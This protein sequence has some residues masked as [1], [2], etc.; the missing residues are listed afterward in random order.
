MKRKFHH[1]EASARELSGPK[2]WRSLDELADTPGFRA[3][4]EREFP[5]GAAEWDNGDR[6]HFLKLMAA[7]FALGGIG[8]A[9]CR[10]PEQN[11]LPFGK[12]VEGII[13]GLP[14]YYATAMPLRK[15][16]IPLLAETHQGRPTKLEGNPTYELHGGAASLQAQ[17]SV[18][19]LYD[20]DRATAHTKA[21]TVIDAKAVEDLLANLGRTYGATRGA[22]LAFLA[23]E[24]SS[25]TR[26]RL[27]ARLRTTFPSAIWAEYE[28]TSDEADPAG[29]RA[30]FGA[31]VK[32]LYRFA[33]A[34]KIVSLDSDFLH[35]E[36]GSLYYARSFSNGRRVTKKED[37]MNRLYVAES[38]L[39]LTGSMADHRLRLASSHILALAAALGTKLIANP[40]FPAS[41]ADGL[42]FKDKDKWIAAC[43]NDLLRSRGRSLVI[44]GA[45]QPAQVHAI[46]YAINDFL[47]NIGQ[48]VDFVTVPAT[49]AASIS[50]VANAI[51][52]NAVKTLIVLGGNPAY[53]APADLDWPTLQ[54]SVNEV[55]RFGGYVDETSSVKPANTT[56]LAAAH[57]LESWGDART[58]D[59]VIVPIQPMILPL[60]GGL[61]EIEVLARILGEANADPYALVS[62]TIVGLAGPGRPAE[63]VMTKFLHDGLLEGSAYPLARVRYNA[64]A[65]GALFANAPKA[66]A[67]SK[68][69]LEVRFVSDY[70]LDDGRFAN[71]GWLQECPDPIT[72]VSWDNAILISP[73]L[74]KEFG[75]EPKGSYPFQVARK[76]ENEFTIGKE[77]ARVFELKVGGK[78]ISGPVHIQPGLSDY[79]VIV[80]LGYGR[81]AAGHIG[82]GAGFSAYPL[83]T[84]AAMS[85]ASGATLTDTGKRMLLANVQEHWSMEGRD[86]VREA[87]LDEYAKNPAFVNGIGMESH[88]PPIYGAEGGKLS[89]AEKATETPRGQSLYSHPNYDGVHQWGMVI[90]MNTCIGCNACVVAC[91]AENNI[92]IVGKDQ[93]LRGR[94]MHWIRI[95]RYYSS[96]T[97]D[98]AAFGGEGNKEIPE[99]PQV[100]LQ[101]MTCQ[102]CETA[103]C[104]TVCPVNATVHDDEGLNTMAY[105]RCIGTRYC[106]NNCPYKVR[107]FNFFD[108]NQRHLDSLYLSQ[109]GPKGMP[110][111]VK[112]VKNP[113]VTVRMRGVMEKCTYCV[114]R[115]Q[116]GKIQHKVKMAKAG[117]P[118]KIEVPD[119]TIKTACQQTCPV[120]A[121]V[122]GN[123]LDQ[124]SAVSKAKSREQDFA[125]LGY[126]NTRPRTTYSAKLRNPNPEMPDYAA[127]K[128]PFSRQEYEKKNHPGGHESHE[129]SHG[130]AG[131]AAPSPSHEEKK[132]EGGHAMLDAA[133]RLG[134][135]S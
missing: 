40:P 131:D 104:E 11:I 1:P 43:A 87:N 107:R 28:P 20:P 6:R 112:M 65:V 79:T 70:K 127:I 89:M 13:P 2:Y 95:D 113:E 16:A 114:Q 23:E 130:G 15:S 109:L 96:G 121:I 67:F 66:S 26:A 62:A 29:A 117:T 44:A 35:A 25:P 24:S 60:F 71:N 61:T 45:H 122:F 68:D 128:T 52:G 83:R 77:N 129:G 69:S 115:I 88:S 119:G 116:N 33:K 48:T 94:E 92:P 37:P 82:K 21:G 42:N 10:R 32:P 18:L 85:I 19:D 54:A 133:K 49:A 78:T 93:V 9:G 132:T 12:S 103:P 101:P 100:S 134:G 135:L 123:I 81:T 3:Q 59:G 22:G 98:A 105:N 51:K 90:D 5:Q 110:E 64:G 27:L 76:E 7:S 53:N 108:Y 36:A 30:A 75:I 118:A 97:I 111:L 74:A 56:H 102:H 91:Q 126:L 17:A 124:E 73:K 125:V 58:V 38:G 41:L 47:G 84:T 86:I 72:K 31:G 120:D 55:I 80:P 57:Y 99:D 4:L 63:Q 8:L 34:E 46:V 39:T 106:A 50:D 14:Q